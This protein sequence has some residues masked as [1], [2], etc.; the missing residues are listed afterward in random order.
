M[1]VGQENQQPRELLFRR[2]AELGRLLDRV[3]R[4]AAGI[5]KAD[6]FGARALRL[7]EK[8]GEIRRVERRAH[9]AKHLRSAA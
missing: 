3:D 9:G 6:H 7:D 4:V 2:D 1:D 5:G 8:R